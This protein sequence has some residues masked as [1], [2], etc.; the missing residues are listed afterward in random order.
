MKQEVDV[1][2][3]FAAQRSELCGSFSCLATLSLS[4]LSCSVLNYD[5]SLLSLCYSA[6]KTNIIE[7]KPHISM[8]TALPTCIV[9]EP[10]RQAADSSTK[11]LG[12]SFIRNKKTHQTESFHL[13]LIE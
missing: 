3:K 12:W 2:R 11:T 4:P 13:I 5:A 9:T 1:T 7:S 6:Q 10:T 8:V